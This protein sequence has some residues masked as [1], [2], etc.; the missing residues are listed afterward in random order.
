[1]PDTIHVVRNRV[2]LNLIDSF[3][4]RSDPLWLWLPAA[5]FSCLD[6]LGL[7]VPATV[8]LQGD[9]HFVNL[10]GELAGF[11]VVLVGHGRFH[12]DANTSRLVR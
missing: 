9:G 8:L 6:Q 11:P 10:A 4:S 7:E 5:V 2:H 1:M 12:V 3:L